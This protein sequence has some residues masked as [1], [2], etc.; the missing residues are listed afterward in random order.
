[1]T[2]ANTPRT[3]YLFRALDTREGERYVFA[4]ESTGTLATQ[5]RWFNRHLKPLGRRL[6][7]VE[8]KASGW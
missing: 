6:L 4:R 5:R 1:M 2:T 7:S 8:P 3:R